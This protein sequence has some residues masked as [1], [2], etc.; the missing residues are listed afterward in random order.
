MGKRKLEETNLLQKQLKNWFVETNRKYNS[1][2][3]LGEKRLKGK[4]R[5]YDE[6]LRKE[7]PEMYEAYKKV[8]NAI[9]SGKLKREPCEVCNNLK[10]LAHHDDYSKPLEVRWFCAS[11]HT[12][13]HLER[14]KCLP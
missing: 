7:H 9:R 8:A 4:K 12:K 3:Y 1:F 14:K 2:Y 13:Y 5:E 6:Y 10:T 11:C